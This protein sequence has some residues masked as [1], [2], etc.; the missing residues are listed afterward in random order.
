MIEQDIII[1]YENQV[2]ENQF[3]FKALQ[4]KIYGIEIDVV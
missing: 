2:H 4:D 1:A 3:T